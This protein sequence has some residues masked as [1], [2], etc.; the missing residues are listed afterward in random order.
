L[1]LFAGYYLQAQITASSRRFDR[2]F[3]EANLTT[4]APAVD[5]YETEHELVSRPII[6]EIKPEELDIRVENKHP[7]HPGDASSREVSENNYLWERSY[8]SFK[9]QL[10]LPNRE[11]P[12]R[13]RGLQ[14]AWLT[15][16]HPEARGSKRSRSR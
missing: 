1:N 9:P 4:W 13:S 5:I 12:K 11:M 3:D 6:P 10:L 2:T 15:L 16:S 14:K 7:H 8:G